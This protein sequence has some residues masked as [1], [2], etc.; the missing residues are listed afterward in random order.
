MSRRAV[1]GGSAVGFSAGWNIAD[2]GAV[3]DDLA[4]A[5]G[6]SLAVIGLFT[7]ALFLTHMLMQFP[8]GA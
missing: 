5:Y 8:R 3:A 6:T 2:T 4:A 7:A 1:A